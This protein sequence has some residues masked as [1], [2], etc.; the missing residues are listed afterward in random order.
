MPATLWDTIETVLSAR[1]ASDPNEPAARR[2]ILYGPP[3][4]GKTFAATRHASVYVI[5]LTE[6]TPMAE[7]RGHYLPNETGAFV[8]HDGPAIR[9]WREGSRLVLNEI[10][11][12]NPDVWSLLYAI[13]DDPSFASLTLPTG[14]TVRPAAGFQCVATTNAEPDVLPDGLRDRFPVRI[15][16]REVNPNALAALSPDVAKIAKETTLFPVEDARR[17]SLR[18]WQAFDSLR[19]AIGLDIAADAVFGNRAR[20][21]RDSFAI[22]ETPDPDGFTDS[23]D[24]DTS[25][26]LPVV[27]G[28]TVPATPATVP[29]SCP[30][31][32][33]RDRVRTGDGYGET[34]SASAYCDRCM[35]SFTPRATRTRRT[36]ATS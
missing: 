21:I 15:L 23:D 17:V 35:A 33:R 32:K 12:A 31:C 10:D 22:A 34:I 25:D 18:Q 11:R 29:P 26:R 3:G 8:W 7:L 5:T 6:E 30:S 36:K 13:A 4:T 20:T 28:R 16:V 1:S 9:A 27:D 19:S 14:E 24:D 2:V